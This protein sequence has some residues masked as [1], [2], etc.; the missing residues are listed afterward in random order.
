MRRLV[1][2]YL[3]FLLF[4]VVVV[5]FGA[6]PMIERL[7]SAPFREDYESYYRELMRG[8]FAL[9]ESDLQEH[10]PAT[11]S[12]RVEAM[13]PDFGF[14]IRLV[15]LD[16]VELDVDAGAT[17]RDGGMVVGPGYD[18]F[19]RT[20][21]GGTRVLVMGPFPN[22]GVGSSVDVWIA[23]LILLV[24]AGAAIAWTLPFAR[25]LGRFRRTAAS[26]GAGDFDARVTLPRHSPLAPLANA[27]DRMADRIEQLVASHRDLTNAV[28]HELRTPLSRIRFGLEM[29]AAESDPT[30]RTQHVRGLQ[31]DVDE[32][33]ALVEE[34]LVYARFDRTT[35]AIE[36]RPVPLRTWFD[37]VVEDLHQ[38]VSATLDVDA[39]QI[40]AEEVCFDPRAMRRVLENLVHNAERYGN[41][42][43]RVEMTSDRDGVRLVVEDDGP[44]IP[45]DQRERIFD[46]FVRLEGSRSRGTGGYGLGLAIVR[47]VV[48]AHAGTV[49]LDEGAYAGCRFTVRWPA[50]ERHA[51]RSSS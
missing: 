18:Q 12:A 8:T 44:G 22:P 11:W 3:L 41:G 29:A 14:P 5:W 37:G 48:D 1:V 13:Q 16:E 39:T 15:D 25:Q 26:F 42:R 20:V 21:G 7:G 35:P 4:V 50:S 23:G 49:T 9:V 34:L 27:F 45:V 30:K 36:V 38:E 31:G 28:A 10:A 2:N 32:L 46:P 43:I 33:E 17:L 6:A 24:V 51:S 47:R 19:W 40:E